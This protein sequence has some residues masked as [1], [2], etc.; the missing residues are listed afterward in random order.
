MVA[1]VAAMSI[2]VSMVVPTIAPSRHRLVV[3]TLTGFYLIAYVGLALAPVGGAWVWMVLSGLGS[4][5]FPL[6]LTMIGLRARTSETTAALSA[7]VQAIGYIVAGSG[8]LLFGVLYGATDSWTMP[9]GLLY[10][11]LAGA[12]VAGWLACRPTYV[13]D[14]L[15][16][17]AP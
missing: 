3:V 9:L 15:A 7:F 6:A 10:V 12:F 2:P 1:L 4:G 17:F 13:D 16:E 5:M 14:E 11:A 8:P